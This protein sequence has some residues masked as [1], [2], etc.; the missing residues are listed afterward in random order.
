MDPLCRNQ[1]QSTGAQAFFPLAS[2]SE[3]TAAGIHRANGESR[4]AMGFVTGAAMAGTPGFYPRQCRV[5]A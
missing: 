5:A 1:D 2:A 3:A 4:V